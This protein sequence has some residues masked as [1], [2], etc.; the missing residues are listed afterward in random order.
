MII[1]NI[2]SGELPLHKAAFHGHKEM[3]HAL[4]RAHSPVD[5]VVSLTFYTH[6]KQRGKKRK[7]KK[8]KTTPMKTITKNQQQNNSKKEKENKQ[9]YQDNNYSYAQL[10]L[11]THQLSGSIRSERAAADVL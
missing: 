4:L 1:I 8:Q 7:K 5:A 6:T 10:L 3:V 2:V 9:K 11:T